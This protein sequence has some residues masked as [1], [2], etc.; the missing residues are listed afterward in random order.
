V[1]AGRAPVLSGVA[2]MSTAIHQQQ[3]ALD[4]TRALSGK[5]ELGRG[6]GDKFMSKYFL[7][8]RTAY[9]SIMSELYEAATQAKVTPKDSANSIEPVEGSDNLEMMQISANF[10]TTY[11]NLIRFVNLIDKSN[12][13]LILE[14]LNATPQQGGKNLN[15]MLKVDT[16][17][18]EDGSAQ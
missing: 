8:R 9:S 5:I 3:N 12:S 14:G 10:E 1:A 4:R 2:E 13:L 18:R 16:Y 15:V 7:P 6:E 11:D 17:V